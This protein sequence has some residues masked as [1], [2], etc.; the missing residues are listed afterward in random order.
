MSAG[1]LALAGLVT[2]LL[3]APSMYQVI[4]CFIRQVNH[5]HMYPLY[6]SFPGSACMAA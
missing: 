6:S 4:V 5:Q 1:C 3:A 2:L